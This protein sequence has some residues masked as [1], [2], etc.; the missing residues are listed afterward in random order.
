MSL[1]HDS[2]YRHLVSHAI[3]V[4][5][6]LRGIVPETW[7]DELDFATLE[8]RGGHYVSDHLIERRTDLVWRVRF[9]G[10]RWLYVY[11]LLEFQSH[12]DAWMALRMLA[13]VSL[14]Y[15]ELVKT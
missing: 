4:E 13:Y 11:L 7:V 5:H 1:P 15:Q 10:D 9:G 8:P 6:L 14:L 3:M 2:G 12:N